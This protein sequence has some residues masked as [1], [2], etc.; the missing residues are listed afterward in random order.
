MSTPFD[1]LPPA[2]FLTLDADAIARDVI[3]GWESASQQA[4]GQ[5][6]TLAP[7][8]PRHTYALF[9]ANLIAIERQ[10]CNYTGQQ[11]LLR[12][13]QG[14]NLDELAAFWGVDPLDPRYGRGARLGATKATTTLLFS[15]P[16]AILSD[17]VIAAGTQASTSN[18]IVFETTADATIAAGLT[19][20]QTAAQATVAGIAANG[21]V[22]GQITQLVQW[23]SSYVVSVTNTTTTAGGSDAETDDAYRQRL[24]L[25]PPSLSGAGPMGQYIFWAYTADP[26]ISD[27]NVWS[28]DTA[29]GI[30]SSFPTW[31]SGTTYHGTSPASVVNYQLGTWMAVTPV[32]GSAPGT[33]SGQW[34]QLRPIGA[35]AGKVFVV[36]LMSGGVIPSS[37]VLNE[38]SAIL[39]SRKI[40]PLT[41]QVIVQAPTTVG[42]NVSVSYY[43]LTDNASSVSSIGEAV[44]NAVN[45][46]ITYTD[47]RLARDID[48]SLLI[49]GMA[50]AGAVKIVVTTPT[51]TTVPNG[52]VALAGT[53]TVTYNGLISL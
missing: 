7:G 50:N 4:T 18:G 51:Y 44:T 37:T 2:E 34:Q 19:S 29:A 40:R 53:V 33:V 17:V 16:E 25:L 30:S 43:I 27:V 35:N 38:V 28:D 32:L 49:Q 5:P 42:Y 12:Y 6:T 14:A 20:V 46:W 21:Y 39:D 24:Y 31:D 52:Q 23:S 9:L 8:D 1:N 45:A 48:P 11:N 3:V 41:D 10:L 47:T 22:S 26:D 13:A 36:P 15:I